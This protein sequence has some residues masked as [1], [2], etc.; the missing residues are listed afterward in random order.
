MHGRPAGPLFLLL[1]LL[2]AP[3]L[4][5]TGCGVGTW[6]LATPIGPRS[7]DYFEEFHIIGVERD[8]WIFRTRPPD[9]Y[10]TRTIEVPAGTEFVVPVL[11]GWE[12]RFGTP[13]EARGQNFGLAAVSLLPGRWELPSDPASPS[14]VRLVFTGLL[15]DLGSDD[16]YTARIWYS[17]IFL[18]RA[19]DPLVPA[20]GAT[21]R[22]LGVVNVQSAFFKET[23]LATSGGLRSTTTLDVP[24]ITTT[25][26]PALRGFVLGYGEYTGP[27]SPHV[28]RPE[29]PADRPLH[30]AQAIANVNP[31][32][33]STGARRPV[34]VG[35]TFTLT[36]GSHSDPWYA[37]LD[38]SVLA[39]APQSDI[40]AAGVPGLRVHGFASRKVTLRGTE[41]GTVVSEDFEVD[42]PAAA[43]D[44]IPL[45]QSWR[46]N[47]G[48]MLEDPTAGLLVWS[49]YERPFGVGQLGI[50]LLGVRPGPT[51]AFRRARLRVSGRVHD[52]TLHPHWEAYVSLNLL[53]L[54]PT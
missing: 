23:G 42:M 3:L 40:D 26:V 52:S 10:E 15:S 8:Q 35:A 27:I 45:M 16:E 6:T 18:R 5:L 21:I 14:E 36:D 50:Q 46:L 32:E 28:N 7:A 54:G 39:L 11:E 49:G 53:F 4:L 1:L 13:D 22:R 24:A 17:L 19:V 30:F 48:Q 31:F 51:P 9:G 25:V 34:T 12:L 29:A 38:A 47:N 44:A 33:P 43:T 2:L 37:A 41:E 20:D